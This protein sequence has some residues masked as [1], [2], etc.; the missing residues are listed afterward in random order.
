[1]KHV[2][3]LDCLSAERCI[4]IYLLDLLKSCTLPK[5]AAL[6]SFQKTLIKVEEHIIRNEGKPILQ[7]HIYNPQF[8]SDIIINPRRGGKIEPAWC[9]SLNESA[10]NRYS[11]VCNVLIAVCRETDNDRLHD[12]AFTCAELT[13]GSND[14]SIEWVAALRTLCDISAEERFYPDLLDQIDIQN[15]SFHN[16][17]A[18]FACILL[19][20]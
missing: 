2:N 14:L 10:S 7:S 16:S 13:A 20:K 9:R 18:V 15:T 11:F 4:I 3:P 8:M 1:M 17:V 19:G 5:T 6:D 12:I